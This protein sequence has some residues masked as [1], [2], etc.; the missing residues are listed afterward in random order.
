VKACLR[1]LPPLCRSLQ[2]DTSHG[3]TS[4]VVEGGISEVYSCL[5]L[6]LCLFRSQ[7]CSGLHFP[8]CL[9]LYLFVSCVILHSCRP[10]TPL[11]PSSNSC[12]PL[13]PASHPYDLVQILLWYQPHELE[14]R[15]TFTSELPL[16]L[17]LSFYL[18][19]A[20]KP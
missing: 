2:V 20:S 18:S 9:C 14:S 3:V 15:T 6:C 4:I 17:P 7:G 10:L 19:P 16:S 5:C 11:L 1:S 13:T 8:L 12:R